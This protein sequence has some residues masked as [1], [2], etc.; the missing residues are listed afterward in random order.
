MMLI[1]SVFW[2][3]GLGW[4]WGSWI[5]RMATSDPSSLPVVCNTMYGYKYYFLPMQCQ[6]FVI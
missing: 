1:T 2:V 5:S 3:T 4:A 6:R